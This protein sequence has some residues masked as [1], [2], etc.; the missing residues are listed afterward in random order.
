MDLATFNIDDGYAEALCRG[1]KT[2]FLDKE[3]YDHLKSCQNMADFKMALEDTDYAPFFQSEP[4]NIEV[5]TIRRKC[6]QKLAEEF[7]HLKAQAVNPLAKFLEMIRYRYMI[8]NAVNM[9]AGL[10]NIKNLQSSLAQEGR[11]PFENILENADPLGYFPEMKSI[12]TVEDNDYSDLYHTVLIDTPIGPYFMKYLDDLMQSLSGRDRGMSEIQNYFNEVKPEQMRICLKK[13]WVEDFSRFCDE[14]NPITRE[15]MGDL[16]K[17]E[18][19]CMSIQIVYNSIGNPE[20][21]AGHQRAGDREQLCP[22]LGYLYPDCYEA[23]KKATNFDMLKDGVKA[24]EEY[25]E[26][27]KDVPDPSKNDEFSAANTQSLDQIMYKAMSKKASM[28]FEQ[29]FHYACF[30]GYLKL[31]EQEIRNIEYLANLVAARLPPKDPAWDRYI[32]PFE[33]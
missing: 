1:W 24:F 31:K 33:Y 22:N 10:K 29:E 3:D 28:A 9:I 18:A 21:M 2:G 16:L 32:V 19:D 11:D 15:M 5:S 8:D 30:Y 20:L 14:L 26:M 13:L 27:L 6:K 4:S 25:R 23:I 12:K 17:F 7:E